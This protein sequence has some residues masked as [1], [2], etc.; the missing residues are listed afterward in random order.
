[1]K[2]LA[3]QIQPKYFTS[4][5]KHCVKCKNINDNLRGLYF[6][7]YRRKFIFQLSLGRGA[8][9]IVSILG[10]ILSAISALFNSWFQPSLKSIVTFILRSRQ[11]KCQL[12]TGTD[13]NDLNSTT[14]LIVACQNL[15]SVF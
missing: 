15:K 7:V 8:G 1:M 14:Y 4:C 9:K 12:S 5:M 11:S 2:I 13:V 10:K 3:K 6:I